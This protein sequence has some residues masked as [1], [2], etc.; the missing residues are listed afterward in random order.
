MNWTRELNNNCN[1]LHDVKTLSTH[2]YTCIIIA[3]CKIKMLE[4]MMKFQIS[5]IGK[6]SYLLE[7]PTKSTNRIL[8]KWFF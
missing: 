1:T 5:I 6:Y 2:T 4:K 7:K 8:K 3:A